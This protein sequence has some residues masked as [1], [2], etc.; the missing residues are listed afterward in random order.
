MVTINIIFDRADRKY[1]PGDVINMEVR[2]HVNSETTIRSIYARIQGF[3]HVQWTESRQVQ[4]D[5]KSHTEHT[6]YS[7]DESYFKNYQTLV[8]S[9]RGK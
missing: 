7:G 2:V 6:T 3:A 8:G 4:R 9:Q 1:S 5:G